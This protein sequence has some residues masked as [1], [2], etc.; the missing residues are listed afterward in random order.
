MTLIHPTS[1]RNH[2]RRL[3]ILFAAF[4]ITGNLL[5]ACVP[6]T[7]NCASE[8]VFCVGLVTDVGKVK[9]N[10]FNQAAWDGIQQA[11]RQW[12]AQVQYIETTNSKDY[13]KNIAAF[14]DMRYDVIVTVGFDPAE[15]TVEAAALHPDTDFIG[16]DQFQ[17]EAVEGV[18]GLIFPEDQAGFLAG[19]LA[20]LMSKNHTIGAVC[21]TD[22]VPAIWRLGEGFKAGAVYVDEEMDSATEVFVIYHDSYNEAFIDP[23]WGAATARSMLDQGAD[24]IFGCGFATGNGAMTEAAQ[25]E[26]YVI[27]V[28]TDQYFTLPQAA[29]QMLSSA[30]KLVTPGVYELIRLAKEGAFPNGNHQGDVGMAPFHELENEVPAEVKDLMNRIS[31][32]LQE[33]SIQ[34]DVPPVK[35]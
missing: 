16:V 34:T 31:S 8:E 1:Q 2:R 13:S 29:P 10:S 26:S 7:I 27:G 28:D 12:G 20:A 14:G 22:G 19:A 6:A 32:G 30:V 23:E 21:A 15:A 18:A 5:P 33:G 4:L 9:D 24:V 25:T 35:P 11:Q 3:H 17:T